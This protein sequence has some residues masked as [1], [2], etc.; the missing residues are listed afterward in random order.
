[1]IGYK[2]MRL[3]ATMLLVG[4]PLSV[5]IAQTDGSTAAQTLM[6]SEFQCPPQE[7]RP[8]VWWHWINGNVTKDGI[9]KDLLWMHR[10]GI[11]GFHCFDAGTV[12]PTIVDKRLVYMDEGWKDAFSYATT[13]ADSL[14][15]EMAV[16]SAPGWSNT[17]GPWVKPEQAMKKL[18]WRQTEVTTKGGKTLHVQLPA[19][20]QTTGFFQN[21][22]PADNAT[23]FVSATITD[24]LYNDIAVIAVR[25]NNAEQTMADLGAKVSSSGGKFTVSQLCDGDISNAS[26]LP[27]DTVRGYAWIEYAFPRPVTIKAL[28][29]SGDP[30][31]EWACAP[32]YVGKHLEASDD[33]QTFRSICDIPNG[34]TYLQTIDIPTTM[35]R[36]FRVRFDTPQSFG[37]YSQEVKLSTPVAELVL[38]PVSRVNHAE[39]KA[40]FATPHDMMDFAT[41]EENCVTPTSD[42]IDVTSGMD[43]NGRLTWKLPRGTWRIYRFGYSLTGKKNHPA[44]PEATGL[45]VDKL[46]RQAMHDYISHYINMYKDATG[47]RIGQRGLQY[48]LVDSYEAGWETWTPLMQEQF[49]RRR[50]YD[51]LPWLP[52]LTGQIIGSA[53]ESEQFL[54]DWRQTIGE[55]IAENLYGEIKTVADSCGLKTYF[56]SHENGRMYL[57][58]GMQ[59]KK[60][61]DTPMAAMWALEGAG[62]ADHTMSECDIRESASVAHIYGQN[63]V[64]LESFTSNGL[65][66]RAYSFYPGNLKPVADL[67]MACGVNKFI[68][69]ESAHQPVDSIRP[70]LGLLIFGQWFNRHETWAEQARGWTD[71]LARSSHMLRHGRNVADILY[72]YGEDNCITG[73]FSHHLPQIPKGYNFDYLNADAL[74]ND[75]DERLTVPSGNSYRLLWLDGNAARMS[76]PVLRK[77]HALAES[78][79]VIAG[80]TPQMCMSLN[81]D[82]TE[83]RLLVN[84]IWHTGRKNVLTDKSL[85]EALRAISLEPDVRFDD[86]DNVR[87]VH[88]SA[89]DAEIYWVNN[90]TDRSR[91]MQASFRITGRKPMLWH[92]ETGKRVPVEYEMTCD[93]RTTVS[94]TMLPW[95]AVFIVFD[96]PTDQKWISVT[97]PEALDSIT[98]S[99]PWTLEFSGVAAPKKL[100]IDRLASLTE[101][102]DSR[103]KYFSGTVVYTNTIKLGEKFAANKH[104]RFVLSLGRV[105]CVA[106]VVVNEKPIGTLWHAPY[107]ID[108]T[109]ALH[110]GS[111]KLEIRVSNLWRNRLIGDKITGETNAF[112]AFDFFTAESPLVPSGLIGPVALRLIEP[113]KASLKPHYTSVRPGQLWLDSDGKP[114]QAHGFQ[115]VYDEKEQTYYWYGEDK[116][117]TTKGSNVWTYGVRCYSS[118]DFYNWTDC[119]HIVFPDTIDALSPI[120][121]SQG[122]DRPHIIYCP[123]TKK[124][125][126]WIKNLNDSTQYFITLQSDRFMGPYSIA[127]RG[128]LPEG[129]ESGDF[130]LWCDP[131]TGRGYVWFER[132]H[133]ELICASLSADFTHT[134]GRVSHHFVGR[135]PPFTREAPT[136]FV[137]DG[138]HYLVTSGTSGYY[139]NESMVCS[140]TNPHGEYTEL[141]SPHPSDTTHTS[142]YSQITSVVRIPRSDASADG[143]LYVALADRWMPQCVGTVEPQREW[144]RMTGV[145]K[146]HKP[147]PVKPGMEI[148]T[149]DR[150]SDLRTGW[151]VTQNARYVFLPIRWIDGKPSIDWM[152]EWQL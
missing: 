40:G 79:I 67:A 47:G 43:A 27:A 68:I 110:E 76:L 19:P 108:I 106:D 123:K 51:V 61:S 133:W 1:M 114:I 48:L 149:A 130:D 140:F 126:C 101:S 55:L 25:L 3:L 98:I 58:D 35:A 94:W 31:N 118:K 41:P 53:E 121:F 71:Y 104:N 142:F 132:P 69:H 103:V 93:G 38:Y 24:S 10:A 151:D 127:N 139:P 125:V 6:Q 64:A 77:L 8:R 120:H 83:F 16:A 17:G 63:L 152:D 62:G 122:L 56:E 13:L 102:S 116:S 32:A 73:L 85:S 112:P 12:S 54:W 92:A 111:N 75:V 146:D 131:A 29:V 44:P 88:R 11:G 144:Q 36:Y 65:G 46:D 124:Y 45:E 105:G 134:E 14:G 143:F 28:S 115:V 109:E 117:Y 135:T 150:S 22:P 57:V 37:V 96:E 119:G 42:V 89:S 60:L 5:C 66:E 91:R 138:R 113:A 107:D 2:K 20:Y 95:D 78:G 90:R 80:Q 26:E 141:G 136:H 81:A 72:Y 99:T 86:A 148:R 9:R 15:M 128:F 147:H 137:Y 30:R 70:G 74:L 52:V 23:E 39:E 100:E 49:L 129:Y 87:Y 50:G 21:V 82:T 4:A 97:E 34:G 84:D 145:F 33:G 59:A 18:T 7:A